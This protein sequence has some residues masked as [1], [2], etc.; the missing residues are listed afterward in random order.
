MVATSIKR[1]LS[2]QVRAQ[3]PLATHASVGRTAFIPYLC[4]I[5]VAFIQGLA[6]QSRVEHSTQELGLWY[7]KALTLVLVI[8]VLH[9]NLVLLFSTCRDP[10]LMLCPVQFQ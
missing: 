10:K 8:A 9:H 1:I 4:V 3:C 7:L 6:W 5:R 2:A